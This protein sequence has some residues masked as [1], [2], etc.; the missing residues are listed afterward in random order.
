ML[1]VLSSWCRRASPWQQPCRGLPL[2]SHSFQPQTARPAWRRPLASAAACPPSTATPRPRKW[3]SLRL[4]DSQTG[5]GGPPQ[6]WRTESV[7]TSGACR[8]GPAPGVRAAADGPEPGPAAAAAAGSG[9]PGGADGAG[10]AG[11]GVK[12]AQGWGVTAGVCRAGWGPEGTARAGRAALGAGGAAF[13]GT[14][15]LGPGVAAW[16]GEAVPGP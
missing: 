11:P 2:L 13:V 15:V 4:Q 10:R 14:A 7:V 5:P 12:G 3:A 8:D 6:G 16:A 9:A 1:G